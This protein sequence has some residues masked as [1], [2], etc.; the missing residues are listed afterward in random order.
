MNDECGADPDARLDDVDEELLA[1]LRSCY[2]AA[3]PMPA[4]LVERTV[5]AL[6]LT[7]LEH[8]LVRLAEQQSLETVGAR[9]EEARVITFDGGHL[10][11]MI[12]ISP[13]RGA[14]RIDG[15][16]APPTPAL[17]ELRTTHGTVTVRADGGGRFV[18]EG[19]PSGLAQFLVRTG[20]GEGD[21]GEGGDG[22]EGG[23]GGEETTSTPAIVL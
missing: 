9:G 20:G 1:A 2:D 8:G 16:L 12:R 11:V 13:Q 22:R 17:V 21:G 10:T 4:E 3:D 19:A 15:W 14:V 6:A 7:D 5:F 23:D 18:F